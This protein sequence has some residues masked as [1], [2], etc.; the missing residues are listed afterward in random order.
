MAE[1]DGHTGELFEN[2]GRPWRTIL[3]LLIEWPIKTP[4]RLVVDH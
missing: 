1:Q 3:E 4:E 2:N